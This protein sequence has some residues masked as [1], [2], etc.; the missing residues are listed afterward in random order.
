MKFYISGKVLPERAAVYFSEIKMDMQKHGCMRI[1]CDAGQLNAI[2]DTPN[3]DI[4]S[5]KLTV[6]HNA[7]LIVSAL[8]FSLNCGYSVEV[9]NVFSSEE[10]DRSTVFGVKADTENDFDQNKV[11]NAALFFSTKNVYFRMALRD[12]MRAINDSM[13]CAFYCYRALE[14]I[15]KSYS[16]G[17]G[18][19]GWLDLH[20]D[21]DT[22]R[23]DVDN[24]ITRFASPIRH[25]RW[26]EAQSTTSAQR[27]EMLTYTQDVLLKFLAKNT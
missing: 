14:A 19:Q 23:E 27:L 16:I 17:Q 20:K 11:F 6:E 8:G 9:I 10:T 2:F 4:V 13:D 1:S 21:L 26:A 5:A 7:Q 25:G 18:S 12:Y 24:K 15:T 3:N 22:N